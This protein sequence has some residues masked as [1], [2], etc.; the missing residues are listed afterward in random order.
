MKQIFEHYEKW[1]DY[2]NGLY[3]MSSTIA[4]DYKLE[5]SKALL[6]NNDL[7]Y[8]TMLKILNDWPIAT[9]VNLTNK[10]CNRRA[11]LGQASCNYFC[12][13]ND[14]IV[15]TAWNS[16]TLKEQS[17]ANETANEIIKI[18]ED[19]ILCQKNLWE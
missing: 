2:K 12:K 3:D 13:A 4:F 6:K 15:K 14:D 1:E 17:S 5:E 11:W 16:L 18:Y 10:G 19:K 8:K 9:S 7:F